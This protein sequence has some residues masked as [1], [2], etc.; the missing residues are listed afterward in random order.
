MS[1]RIVGFLV[2]AALSAA[3][4]P[5]TAAAPTPPPATATQPVAPFLTPEPT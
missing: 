1:K 5:R 4:I 2:C 3:C